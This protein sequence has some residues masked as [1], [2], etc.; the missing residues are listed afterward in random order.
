MEPSQGPGRIA[1]LTP[2]TGEA[3]V[4]ILLAVPIVLAGRGDVLAFWGEFSSPWPGAVLLVVV[5]ALLY[6]V[7]AAAHRRA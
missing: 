5:M 2:P 1:L 7:A 3:L 4:G 6:R